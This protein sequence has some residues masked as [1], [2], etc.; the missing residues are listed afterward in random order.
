[1][2]RALPLLVAAI[3]VFAWWLASRS[4]SPLL[5]PGPG[6]VLE[7]L[8]THRARLLEATWVTASSALLGLLVASVF[9]LGGAALFLR[10]RW[11][12]LA[13]YPYALLLQTLPIIAI[14]PLLVV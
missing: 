11:L 12:E 3:A 2:K 4:V 13:L 10:S 5:L 14:A 6:A 8:A 7:A 9:G 1:M